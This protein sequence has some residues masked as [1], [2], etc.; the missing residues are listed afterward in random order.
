MFVSSYTTHIQTNNSQKV[1]KQEFNKEAS[2]S[3]SFSSQLSQALP[4]NS[5]HEKPSIPVD[6]ISKALVL[7]NKQELENKKSTDTTQDNLEKFT[8]RSSLQSAKEAYEGNSKMFSLV[9][10]PKIALN[11]TPSVENTLP[12]EPKDIKELHMRHQMVNTYISND[13]YYRVTA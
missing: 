3:K 11:Q 2:S 7:N 9:T 13:N 8:L 1:T 12:P 10:V 5:S 4:Q 6:Y